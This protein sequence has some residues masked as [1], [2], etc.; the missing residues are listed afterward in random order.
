MK[1]FYFAVL[2]LAVPGFSFAQGVSECHAILA[3]G[4][5]NT[6]IEI[7]NDLDRRAA[8]EYF[9][10]SSFAESGS[11]KGFSLAAVYKGITGSS[12]YSEGTHSKLDS[13]LCSAAD[14]STYSNARSVLLRQYVD[15]N[16]VDKWSECVKSET[17]LVCDIEAKGDGIYRLLV[18]L[19]DTFYDAYLLNVQ[20]ST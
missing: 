17:N 1:N 7:T 13:E 8:V 15:K 5:F 14:R 20:L 2:L 6:E 19:P 12:S 9:C 18:E 3:G 10:S 11:D 4:K 16:S